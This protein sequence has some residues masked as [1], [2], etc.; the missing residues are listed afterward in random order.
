MTTQ[1]ISIQALQ[2]W[3]QDADFPGK[4]YCE[5]KDNGDL[6]IRKADTHN[7]RTIASLTL[8]N[9]NALT[10]ALV[11]KY[12][13][14][15][16][17]VK[18]LQQEW[19]QSDDKL[20]L[21]GKVS[22]LKEYLLHTNAIGNFSSLLQQVSVWEHDCN[23]L[24]DENY[25]KKQSL[26][27]Q[28][29]KIAAEEEN[30]K[31]GTKTFKELAEQWKQIGFVD[32]QRNDELLNRF[33]TAK[34]KFYERKRQHHEDSEK[35]MLQNLD[36]KM[37]IVER[38]SQLAGSEDWKQ[39]TEDF[40]QLMDQ[41]KSIGHTWND[42]N[43]ELWNRFILAKNTFFERKNAH[44]EIIKAEQEHNYTLKLA[45]LEKAE[46][47][48]DSKDW[49]KTTNDYAALMEEWKGIGRVPA[50][51]ADELWKRLHAAKDHFFANKR[52]HTET[53][54]VAMEDNYARKLAL[55]KR[56]EEL[57]TSTQWREATE[58]MNELF[59]E[60]KK[61]GPVPRVHGDTLWEQFIA[62]RKYFFNCKDADRERRK[63]HFEKKMQE[64]E[65]RAKH[66]LTELKQELD[67]EKE[68][69]ADFRTA[70]ENVTPGVKEKEL[71]SHLE[72]LIKGCEQ[73]IRH[74]EQ[75]IADVMKQAEEL[76]ARKAES[77]QQ[78]AETS[79]SESKTE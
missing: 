41:W 21:M 5:L 14:V 39:T 18:E 79:T 40:R 25:N 17:R 52:Q 38:A 45:L 69:L 50:E 75:M 9:A 62:A 53:L 78:T 60:W 68:K 35:E 6:V 64:K 13:E 23:L 58:E 19:E 73:K 59:N 8:E 74:K 65:E 3:W 26:T 43:E 76:E 70:L 15:E 16:G 46:S 48:K 63:K 49:T 29:E 51:K 72:K 71:R 12:P 20:K 11:E 31:E 7:E 4:E 34:N 28:A 30:W 1:V 77:E 54:R 57:K 2:Q 66:F 36:L 22:R 55:A 61:I 42:K 32:K 33:E 47:W 10:K 56:A 27:E 44:F 37:E 24:V 67:E